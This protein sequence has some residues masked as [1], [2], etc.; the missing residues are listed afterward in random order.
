VKSTTE[1]G[2]NER[3]SKMFTIYMVKTVVISAAS[4]LLPALVIGFMNNYQKRE[5]SMAYGNPYPNLEI[6][7][8]SI[9]AENNMTVIPRSFYQRDRYFVDNGPDYPRNNDAKMIYSLFLGSYP[10]MS[11]LT[12]TTRAL[13][14]FRPTKVGA[15][16]VFVLAAL[17]SVFCVKSIL[18]QYDTLR[19]W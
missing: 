4:C 17:V 1:I 8:P 18:F 6:S 3:F 10:V 11:L 7:H 9:Y 5:A 12:N 2:K 13:I 16:I 15:S 19:V 14:L